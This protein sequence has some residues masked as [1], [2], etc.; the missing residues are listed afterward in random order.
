VRF[1][2]KDIQTQVNLVMHDL[3]PYLKK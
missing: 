2:P 1:T 3:K